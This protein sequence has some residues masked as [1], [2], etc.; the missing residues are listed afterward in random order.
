MQL[1]ES[2]RMCADEQRESS[3]LKMSAAMAKQ[4]NERTNIV[5]GPKDLYQG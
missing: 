2:A 4:S 1:D 3:I 5:Q